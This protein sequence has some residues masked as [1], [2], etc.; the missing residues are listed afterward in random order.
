MISH[1]SPR[2][3]SALPAHMIEDMSVLGFSEKTRS[4]YVRNV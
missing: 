4:D 3:V 1:S 2:P